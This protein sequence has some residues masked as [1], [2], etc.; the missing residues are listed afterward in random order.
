MKGE[1]VMCVRMCV[2]IVYV[3]SNGLNL[4]ELASLCIF[5]LWLFAL[6]V[7]KDYKDEAERQRTQKMDMAPR[8]KRGTL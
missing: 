2:F 7:L 5:S 8:L 6:R 3:Y 4:Y 1:R